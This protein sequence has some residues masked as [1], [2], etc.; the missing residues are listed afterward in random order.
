MSESNEK[1]PVPVR[2]SQPKCAPLEGRFLLRPRLGRRTDP[3]SL[4]ELLNSRRT[5]LPFIVAG[6]RDAETMLLVRFNIDW[7]MVDLSVDPELIFPAKLER[8]RGEGVELRF[9][10]ESRVV[11]TIQWYASHKKVRL[12]DFLNQSDRFIASQ[13]S[14]GTLIWNR[15]RV[16][17]ARILP[18]S[19]LRLEASETE[20]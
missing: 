1:I 4:V 2:L 13:V 8:N 20:R 16:R 5:V 7:V 18:V 6:Q 9:M 14:H 3:E 17:A 11:A 15:D 12:S 10:D 19:R